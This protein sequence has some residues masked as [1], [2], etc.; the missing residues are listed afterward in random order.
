MKIG[1]L[2]QY[3]QAD[4]ALCKRVGFKSCELLVGPGSALD[5]AKCHE[6][7]ILAAKEEMQ[8]QGIEVSAVGSY[9]NN[10]DPDPVKRAANVAHMERLMRV[11]ELFGINTICTFAGRIPDKDI[12]DN[13]P[14]FKEVFG[15]L[16]KKLEDRG[17]RLAFENCPMFHYFPFRGVN[18]AYTP[19]AW[20][21]MFD[22]VPS[23]ALGLE[24]DPSHLICLLMDYIEIVYRYGKKIFH[25]H[26]KDAEVVERN[27][28]LNG[29]LEPGAVRHRTP[30]MGQVDWPLL[31]SALREN[32]YSGNLDI[33]G[34]HDPIFHGKN[35]E[36]GLRISYNCLAKLVP[37]E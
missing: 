29:I 18:I 5:P 13:I 25:V 35:E 8:K 11:A 21:L 30:G 12:P 26:A 2:I 6:K 17:L 22:A 23:P 37:Q 16:A 33:E 24:Y 15:P 4:I 19:R 1:L 3:S 34:R 9:P 14:A 31:I 32:G 28:K 7:D 36:E 27:V 10:L 20:D